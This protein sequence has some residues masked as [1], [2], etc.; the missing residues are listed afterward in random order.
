MVVSLRPGHHLDHRLLAA[1]RLELH[2]I[3]VASLAHHDGTCSWGQARLREGGGLVHKRGGIMAIATIP[4]LLQF[5]IKIF[6]R[7][8][9]TSFLATYYSSCSVDC[10]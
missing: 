6:F 3:G 2:H 10:M 9:Y 1:H 4:L 8:M 7:Y 5:G